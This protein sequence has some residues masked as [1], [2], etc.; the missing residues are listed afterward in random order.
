M[1]SR[2]LKSRKEKRPL[3]VVFERINME[4]GNLLK[5]WPW[6]GATQKGAGKIDQPV[7]R[8]NNKLYLVHRLV[9]SLYKGIPYKKV[10]KLTQVCNNSICCNP[11][12]IVVK[13]GNTWKKQV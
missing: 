9:Y 8:I 4:G 13:K 6:T 10:P 11:T 3:S 2:R 1:L 5:C 7:T 12:H